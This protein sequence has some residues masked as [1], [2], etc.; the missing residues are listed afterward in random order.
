M[1][2]GS[3]RSSWGSPRSLRRLFLELWRRGRSLRSNGDTSR[4]HESSIWAIKLT[5]ESWRLHWNI[6]NVDAQQKVM[7]NHLDHAIVSW[8]HGDTY[9]SIRGY[10]GARWCILELWRLTSG[11]VDAHQ[12]QMAQLLK[13]IQH[14]KTSKYNCFLIVNVYYSQIM[15]NKF[16]W[17]VSVLAKHVFY[18]Q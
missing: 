1:D 8:I 2:G 12:G 7:E 16:V 18:L 5:L 11:E 6:E 10:P 14:V 17:N 3:P 13:G 4:P 9:N 15:W